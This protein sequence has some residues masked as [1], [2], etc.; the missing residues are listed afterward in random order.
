[1]AKKQATTPGNLIKIYKSG[2]SEN[3][4]YLDEA[5][6][7]AE[8]TIPG[9]QPKPSGYGQDYQKTTGSSNLLESRDNT[10]GSKTFKRPKSDAGA[11]A[12]KGFSSTITSTLYPAN[13]R[14]FR[15]GTDPT[16]PLSEVAKQQMED[17]FQD[18]ED[19]VAQFLAQTSFGAF[20]NT[21]T[22][23]NLIEGTGAVK[24]DEDGWYLYPLRS[25][26]VKRFYGQPQWLCI[27]EV[28]PDTVKDENGQTKT[29]CQYIYID[30]ISQEIWSQRSDEDKPH[31][32]D[33][34]DV[35]QYFI[36]V[37]DIPT[38]ENYG[39]AFYSDHYGLL[40]SIDESATAL[41][42][43]MK[44]CS[45]KFLTFTG[46]SSIPVSRIAAIKNREVIR[47]PSHEAIKWQ[48]CGEAIRDWE[49]VAAF[50]KDKEQDIQAISAVGLMSR[51]ANIQTATEVVEIRKELDAISGS[52]SQVLSETFLKSAINAVIDLLDIR[53]EVQRAIADKGIILTDE[54]M[55]KLIE[56]IVITG[57]P[58]LAREQDS[59]KLFGAVQAVNSVFGPQVTA[60]LFDVPATVRRYL[61]GLRVD[62]ADI[63]VP[64]PQNLQVTAP[65]TPQQSF[66]PPG[67]NSISQLP[68]EVQQQIALQAQKANAIAQ[69]KTPPNGP[70][71]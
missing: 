42:E 14:S 35:S 49:F 65:P 51:A 70:Q 8:L 36:V 47:F 26:R 4:Q 13:V 68:P 54:Q 39:R 1:M 21:T 57:T 52:V 67:G 58:A 63:L 41:N 24:V 53:G 62:T 61:D 22:T 66:A 44:S 27:E 28:T 40:S 48:T 33:S 5:Q 55:K 12:V 30:Y 46:P 2:Q 71:Q 18:Q 32:I 37:T 11:R 31:V 6:R 3:D 56:P 29:I 38:N 7:L 20:F 9:L 69:L 43:A 16:I 45:W 50:L 25:I 23:R 10:R 17:I 60:A 34:E 59:Q 64:N 15:F 19:R